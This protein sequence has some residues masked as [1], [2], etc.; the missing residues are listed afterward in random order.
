MFVLK[1]MWH[2]CFLLMLSITHG[3]PRGARVRPALLFVTSRSR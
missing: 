1:L 3:S 2:F